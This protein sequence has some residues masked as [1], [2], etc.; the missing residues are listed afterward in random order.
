MHPHPVWNTHAP[1]YYNPGRCCHVVMDQLLLRAAAGQHNEGACCTADGRSSASRLFFQAFHCAER[2]A[3]AGAGRH[4]DLRLN[5]SMS[6]GPT[7]FSTRDRCG[8]R[9]ARRQRVRGGRCCDDLF[10]FLSGA[11]LHQ[12]QEERSART[13]KRHMCPWK[14]ATDGRSLFFFLVPNSI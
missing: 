5:S 7:R 4:S 1:V 3:D 14:V 2:R 10:W 13:R 9:R 11:H 12:G 8:R 6:N